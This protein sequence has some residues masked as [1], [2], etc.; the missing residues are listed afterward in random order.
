M[1]QVLPGRGRK[2]KDQ[3]GDPV[4]AEQKA[5]PR[6]IRISPVGPWIWVLMALGTVVRISTDPRDLGLV[7]IALVSIGAAY[8][9]ERTVIAQHR[10]L[11][12]QADY[13]DRLEHAAASLVKQSI[14]LEHAG[15]LTPEGNMILIKQ[16]G[17]VKSHKVPPTG[18]QPFYLLP[19]PKSDKWRQP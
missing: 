11:Q 12:N 9:F 10:A 18:S 14:D 3:A 8:R 17:P 15:W 7:V 2:G 19:G 1:R 5:D 16:N 6:F 13:V 4:V